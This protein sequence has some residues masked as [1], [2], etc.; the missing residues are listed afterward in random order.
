MADPRFFE[1]AGPFSMG[2][3]AEFAGAEIIAPRDHGNDIGDK[4]F[5]NVAPLATAGSNDVSF[6]DNRKYV[7]IFEKSKAGAVLLAPDLVERAPSSTALLVTPDPYIGYAKVA[8]SYYPNI[9]HIAGVAESAHVSR[10][11][12]IGGDVLIG[13]GAVIEDNVEIGPGCRI[14]ANTV[15]GAGVVIGDSGNIGS[16][17][18]IEYCCIGNDAVIHSGVR[19]GQDGFG[20]APGATHIK[21]PQLG[22]VIIGNNVEIGASTAIDR[23]AALDTVIGDGSKIDN[24][25]QI[26]HNVEIGRG[27]LIASQVGIAGSAKI[28]N[29]VM[30]GG[31]VGIAGHLKIGDGVKIAAQSGVTRDIKAGETVA[32]MPAMK[33]RDFW[34]A[35]AKLKQLSIK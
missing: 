25:V 4:L 9:R 28:G 16:N 2:Q 29:Y 17:V 33:A 35:M 11:A 10:L 27:C 22:R 19:I 18:T 21:V 5:T 20:F 32:G 12:K 7:K 26:A 15:I 1:V 13:P 34:R 30:M 31:Q 14:G 23:G 24:L 3:L 6:V 8:Q